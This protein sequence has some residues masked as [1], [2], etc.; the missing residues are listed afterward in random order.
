MRTCVLVSPEP[1]QP[2]SGSGRNACCRSN[3]RSQR[4]ALALPDWVVLRSVS[5]MR[6]TAMA[7]PW[8]S[9]AAESRLLARRTLR[10]ALGLQGRR[11]RCRILGPWVLGIA[12]AHLPRDFTPAAGP[13]SGQVAGGLDRPPS[14]RGHG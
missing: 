11:S 7:K 9:A 10:R 13:E 5:E 8:Q 1:F 2:V 3:S 6:A 12:A 14:W 4:P